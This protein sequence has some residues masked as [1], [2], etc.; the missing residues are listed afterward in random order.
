VG[1]WKRT[2]LLIR[3]LAELLNGCHAGVMEDTQNVPSGG[4]LARCLSGKWKLFDFHFPSRA[5]RKASTTR[6]EMPRAGV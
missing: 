2:K 1:R 6:T 5:A 3:E 4:A